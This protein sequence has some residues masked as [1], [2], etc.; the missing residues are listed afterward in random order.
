MPQVAEL[1]S[2]SL[3]LAHLTGDGVVITMEEKPSLSITKAEVGEVVNR[4]LS[5]TKA[6]AGEV[7]NRSLFME[8]AAVGRVSLFGMIKSYLKTI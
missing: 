6:E 1:T 3:T 4:L 5:I 2:L 8:V 7:V